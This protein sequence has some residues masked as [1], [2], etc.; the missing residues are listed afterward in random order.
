MSGVSAAASTRPFQRYRLAISGRMLTA[1][2]S[3]A[4]SSASPI[5]SAT[6]CEGQLIQIAT[7]SVI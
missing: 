1:A 6:A 2:T 4:D 5:V 7:T 3:R